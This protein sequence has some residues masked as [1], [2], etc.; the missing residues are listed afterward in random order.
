M[1]FTQRRGLSDAGTR[2][3]RR[4]SEGLGTVQKQK[5]GEASNLHLWMILN[6][7]KVHRRIS[8]SG[9]RVPGTDY[10]VFDV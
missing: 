3:S 2:G 9:Y 10:F 6:V 8:T 5:S 4:R 1:P 7:I